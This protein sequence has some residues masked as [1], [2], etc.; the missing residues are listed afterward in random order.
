MAKSAILA[1]NLKM[2][3]CEMYI[4]I[5]I[6][7]PKNEISKKIKFSKYVQMSDYFVIWHAK[8]NAIESWEV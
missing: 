5:T 1:I 4:Q 8:M 3:F 7:L 2:N 6:T